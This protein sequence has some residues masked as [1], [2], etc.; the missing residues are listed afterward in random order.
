RPRYDW[1]PDQ[2]LYAQVATPSNDIYAQTLT[3]DQKKAVIEL[4]PPIQGLSYKPPATLEEGVKKFNRG[5][6]RE[7][8]QLKQLQYLMSA[9]LRPL[10]VLGHHIF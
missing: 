9:V 8:A 2:E 7:D 1:I 4:Y 10:D 3:E 6:Q 5:Q